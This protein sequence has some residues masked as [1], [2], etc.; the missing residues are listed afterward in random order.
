M[1][2]QGCKPFDLSCFLSQALQLP[3]SY[4]R[5][6]SFFAS[7]FIINQDLSLPHKCTCECCSSGTV[8]DLDQGGRYVVREYVKIPRRLSHVNS[9]LYEIAVSR[10]HLGQG[11]TSR[12]H[13]T[14]TRPLS[15]SRHKGAH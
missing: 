7:T 12:C 14:L 2:D 13:V 5:H 15:L 1:Q 8:A 6:H 9:L 3:L 4:S 11:L 10:A